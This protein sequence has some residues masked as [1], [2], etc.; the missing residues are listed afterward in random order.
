[1]TQTVARGELHPNVCSFT[2]W[3]NNSPELRSK[4]VL[5][6][7]RYRGSSGVCVPSVRKKR[8][9][10]TAVIHQTEYNVRSNSIRVRCSVHRG[11]LTI[12]LTFHFFFCPPPLIAH[13]LS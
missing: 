10:P 11:V 1:M 2:A 6:I 12:E 4:L 13:S 8:G 9:N 7:C 5:R 3:I